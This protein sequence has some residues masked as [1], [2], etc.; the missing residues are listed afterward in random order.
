MA[1]RA[2]VERI[3]ADPK[4]VSAT[5]LAGFLRF[6]VE[7]E[8]AGRGD[9]VKE[10]VIGVGAYGKGESYDPR[11]DPT[12]RVD[13]HK[14][15]ARLEEFYRESGRNDPIEISIPKGTYVP[16]F[17]HRPVESSAPQAPS[18][19]RQTIWA[20]ACIPV[21]VL[22]GM[23][24][25]AMRKPVH[26]HGPGEP[27]RIVALASYPGE[28]S[29][30]ALSPDGGMVA[31]S[32]N[33]ESEDNFDIYVKVVDAP[34]AVR[35]TRQ[36][37][38]DATPAWSPD[39]RQIAFV[40][41]PGRT[42]EV[43]VI[44]ALGGAER[45][46]SGSNASL[47]GSAVG[48]TADSKSVLVVDRATPGEPQAGFVVSLETGARRQL[49]FPPPESI[50]G[51]YDLVASPDGRWMAFCR[52]IHGPVAELWLAPVG[53]G[54]A[55]KVT[56]S[57]RY[58]GGVAWTP[59]SRRIVYSSRQ[60]GFS[61]LWIVDAKPDS[62]GEPM[63]EFETDAARPSVAPRAGAVDRMAY[64]RRFQ[65]FRLWVADVREDG[66]SAAQCIHPSLRTDWFPDISADGERVVFASERAGRFDIWMSRL[67]GNGLTNLTA[68]RDVVSGAPRWS[69][70]G[71]TIVFDGHEANSDFQIYTVPAA[72][73]PPRRLTSSPDEKVRPSWSADG[74]W[75]YFTSDKSGRREIW[76]MPAEGGAAAQVTQGGGFQPM[77]SPDGKTLY[78]LETPH[79]GKLW[80]MPVQGGEARLVIDDAW[81]ARWGVSEKG[82]YFVDAGRKICRIEESGRRV[83]VGKMERVGPE[84]AGIGVSRDGRK[85][86]FSQPEPVQ[87]E[88][89]MAEGVFFR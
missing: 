81:D 54:T 63:R 34:N 71:R 60:A 24:W 21:L 84:S 27:V 5:R 58:L 86:V 15:R 32:W 83:C 76:K 78:Y 39:G 40:R 50:L 49:T 41:N 75:I 47:S 48:W 73:G 11:T 35:L 70:D 38:R 1:I 33:G 62:D 52:M 67:D 4:F 14:L 20:V 74:K 7:E 42:G 43:Y 17:E 18:R 82:V 22:G 72:G 88:L 45:R 61:A 64:Q 36:P 77:E 13:A 10:Y 65:P 3:L 80:R 16:R 9:E 25:L 30:P 85:I 57:R 55:T 87:S 44:S 66:M 69:P 31:F 46:V 26:A 68:G 28:Q 19:R 56:E 59:D 12:V 2:Q 79:S 8:L 37:A 51:D 23:T 6:V 29:G 53:G 89:R